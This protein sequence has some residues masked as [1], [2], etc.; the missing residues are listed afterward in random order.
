MISLKEAHEELVRWRIPHMLTL[1]IF[2]IITINAW[3][4]YKTNFQVLESGGAV[5][6]GAF[7]A[8]SFGVITACLNYMG[9]KYEKDDHD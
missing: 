6:F 2:V 9:K 5:A 3:E 4:F 8:L 1:T 7:C